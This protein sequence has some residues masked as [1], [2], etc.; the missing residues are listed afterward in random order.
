M[1]THWTVGIAAM[2]LGGG[3]VNAAIPDA[4]GKINA[5][6]NDA[7]GVVRVIDTSKTGSLGRCITTAGLL[8]ETA[9]S[10]SQTGPA[11]VAGLGGCTGHR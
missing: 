8:H 2:L 9:L 6:I 5:C 1:N 7:T 4:Q 10:W 3:I 11:G